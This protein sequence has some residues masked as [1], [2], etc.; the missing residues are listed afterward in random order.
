MVTGPVALNELVDLGPCDLR[1]STQRQ[2]VLGKK[3]VVSDLEVSIN[4][5]RCGSVFGE[6]RL[7]DDRIASLYDDTH[8]YVDAA[9]AECCLSRPF[10]SGSVDVLCTDFAP[11]LAGLMVGNDPK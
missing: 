4:Q 9:L 5:S 10:W 1:G 8:S 3:G 6:R 7:S 11:H 2:V